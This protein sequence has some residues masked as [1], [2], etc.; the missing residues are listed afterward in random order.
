VKNVTIKSHNKKN[1]SLEKN[2]RKLE[3]LLITQIFKVYSPL[4]F[5]YH[6]CAFMYQRLAYVK[7]VILHYE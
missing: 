7:H 4:H 5:M 2:Y 1:E 3:K 6:R